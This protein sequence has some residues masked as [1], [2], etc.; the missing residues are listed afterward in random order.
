M[1]HS[2][3]QL[4]RVI[5]HRHGSVDVLLSLEGFRVHFLERRN[6]VVPL[7]QSR[8]RANRRMACSYNF[9][10]GSITG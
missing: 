4:S 7:Q 9:Q 3:L 6:A 1:R 8:R 5:S 10:T 2:P